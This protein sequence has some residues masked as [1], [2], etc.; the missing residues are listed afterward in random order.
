MK[1]PKH[2]TF[3]CKGCGGTAGILLEA[4]VGIAV[5]GRRAGPAG[6]VFHLKPTADVNVRKVQCPLYQ[7]LD[8]IAFAELHAEEPSLE[9]VN[10]WRKADN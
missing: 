3:K 5:L 10:D 9:Q 2:R 4:G 1:Q 7:R 8:A 6:S